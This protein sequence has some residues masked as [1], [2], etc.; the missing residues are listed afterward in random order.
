[1]GEGELFPCRE[2]GVAFPRN[3]G[4][5]PANRQQFT[6]KLLALVALALKALPQRDRD[7]ARLGLAGE[8]R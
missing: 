6:G 5:P 8:F 1:M 7:S 2:G 3:G 4:S